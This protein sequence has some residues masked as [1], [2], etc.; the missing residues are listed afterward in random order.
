MEDPW[1]FLL[2]GYAISA[3]IETP[4]L[5]VGLSHPHGW[6]RRLC[7][8]LWLTACTYP[9]VILFF[10]HFFNPTSDRLAYLLAAETF[11]PVAECFLFWLAFRPSGQVRRD[12]ICIVLANLASFGL[13]ETWYCWMG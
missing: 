8:G 2:L 3:A 13:G 9:M 4:I 6:A 11:A 5:L 1:T 7:A 12:C 10:P